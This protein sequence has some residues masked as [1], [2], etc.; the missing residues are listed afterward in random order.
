MECKVCGDGDICKLFNDERKAKVKERKINGKFHYD[1][2]CSN[3]RR[4]TEV[5][6]ILPAISFLHTC[7]CQTKI[8]CTTIKK[9]V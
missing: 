5:E 3:C 8:R 7:R 1:I 4:S 6:M 2:H 9:E